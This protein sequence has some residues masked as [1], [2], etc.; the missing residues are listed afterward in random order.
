MQKFS[1]ILCLLGVAYLSCCSSTYSNEKTNQLTTEQTESALLSSPNTIDYNGFRELTQTTEPYR[2][3]RLIGIDSFAKMMVEDDVLVLDTRSKAAYDDIHIKGAVHLN[4]SDFTADKLAKVIPSKKTRILIYCN[5]NFLDGGLSLAS[6]S[7]RLALNIPTFINLVGYGY[8]DVYEL[9]NV[10][11]LKD[12]K[13]YLE[14]EGN[15]ISRGV[16]NS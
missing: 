13:A 2:Q 3:K 1:F 10:I 4:F 5:N 14:F 15:Y 11:S 7:L 8:K 9:Q 16:S 12:A 6:K